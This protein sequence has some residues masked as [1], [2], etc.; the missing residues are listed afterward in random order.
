MSQTFSVRNTLA[1]FL[2]AV[3][4]FIGKAQTYFLN[5]DSVVGIPDT[6]VNGQ[7][8]SFTLWLT[9][10]S[11]LGFQGSVETMLTFPDAQD[12]LL[13]ADS[14]VFATSFLSAQMQSQVFVTHQFTTEGSDA[15]VLGDNVVVVWP[16]IFHGPSEPSQE[17]TKFFTA[18]FH[19]VEPLGVVDREHTDGM[20][21][22][23]NPASDVVYIELPGTER[24]HLVELRDF[25]GRT[26]VTFR[27]GERHIPLVDLP[28]GLYTVRTS[29]ESG[30]VFHSRLLV[31]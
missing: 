5:V 16:K 12:S 10:Q 15:M 23:P 30:R 9:N 11:N 18:T 29:T 24:V 4:P 28:R 19:L 13:V 3:A 25:T 31:R 21:I 8:V 6:I 22:Y 17:V 20:R 27:Q 2:L 1:A 26:V 7:S 14:S